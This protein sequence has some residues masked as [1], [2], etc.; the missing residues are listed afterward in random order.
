MRLMYPVKHVFRNWKLFAALL[1]GVALAATFFAGIGVK[2]DVA[3]EE[4][5]DKQLSY[6]TDDMRLSLSL[7]QTNLPIAMRN[8]A[9]VD[10]VQFV[11]VVFR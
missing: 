4:S 6:I 8:I 2:V 3:A 7:N 9:N 10:G 1:I 11:D 5:V